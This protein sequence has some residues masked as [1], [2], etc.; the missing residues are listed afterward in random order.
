[1]RILI[2]SIAILLLIGCN[3][4]EPAITNVRSAEDNETALKNHIV[5]MHKIKETQNKD[6]FIKAFKRQCP[7]YEV[8][9]I[10][11]GEENADLFWP[12]FE[13]KINERCE[14]LRLNKYR[15]PSRKGEIKEIILEDLWDSVFA[16][17]YGK[18]IKPKNI[19]LYHVTVKCENGMYMDK[20]YFIINNRVYL[21]KGL[22]TLNGFLKRLKENNNK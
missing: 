19:P 16:D 8:L 1:M 10:L 9:S 5:S 20:A 6:E 15:M 4:I 2:F 11:L 14:K 7:D 13:R 17:E 22:Y 18:L 12:M 3:S 21:L